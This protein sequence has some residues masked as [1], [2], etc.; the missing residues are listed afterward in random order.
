MKIPENIDFREYFEMIGLQQSQDLYGIDHWREGLLERLS[1]SDILTGNC[2]PWSKTHNSIRLRPG[3]ISL[4]AGVNGHRKSMITGQVALW[5]AREQ[6]VC[7]ASLEMKP[8]STIERMCSQAAGC[9]PSPQFAENFL[10]WGNERIWIYDKLDTTPTE[11]IL[12]VC[13]YAAKEL[14][15]KHVFIDSL[16]KCGISPDDYP[17][18]KDFVDRLALCA[19]QNN[20]HIHLICHMRKGDDE[21][22]R[23]GKFDVK[24]ASEI[25]DLVDNV[26]VCW[27]DKQREE[28]VLKEDSNLQLTDKDIQALERCDQELRVEKQRHGEWES[29]FRLWFHKPS[30]Q[31][32]GD[33]KNHPMPFPIN[34]TRGI[35]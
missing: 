32:I 12:G 14:G 9:R 11:S 16:M 6:P 30:L 15:C 2:L 27:K 5:L 28:A 22:R 8:E 21:Y 4:W 34:E 13:Y 31:F 19:K 1:G 17:G 10:E 20:I 23:P 7:I 35:A 3:E 18:Q 24:G 26:F 29:T 25:T 33:T